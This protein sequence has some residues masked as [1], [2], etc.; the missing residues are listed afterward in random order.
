MQATSSVA[1]PFVAELY[2]LVDRATLHRRR[3]AV[4]IGQELARA[5]RARARTEA[6]TDA[7]SS[8]SPPVPIRSPPWLRR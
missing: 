8:D 3:R 1:R 7:W 2:D 6:R 4:R 5:R